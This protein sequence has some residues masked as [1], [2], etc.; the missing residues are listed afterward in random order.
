VTASIAV[1]GAVRAAA[2]TAVVAA[3]AA[4]VM[5]AAAG[6]VAPVEK[7]ADRCP[8]CWGLVSSA[9]A[10]GHCR[11]AFGRVCINAHIDAQGMAAACPICRIPVFP[12]PVTPVVPVLSPRRRLVDE[13]WRWLEESESLS[14][15]SPITPS[16]QLRFCRSG[17]PADVRGMEGWTDSTSEPGAGCGEDNR[18]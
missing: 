3:A 6:S 15:S 2:T 12:G 11:H 18:C 17:C 13:D 16:N 7:D 4:A 5:T 14:E 1:V 8:I 9:V 10:R